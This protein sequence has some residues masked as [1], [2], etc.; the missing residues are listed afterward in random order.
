MSSNHAKFSPSSSHR[1]LACPGSISLSEQ[2]P[3]PPE[4]AA[5]LEGTQAHECLELILKNGPEKKLAT[6]RLLR[7]KYPLQMVVH[8]ALSA[9]SIWQL[10]RKYL[11]SALLLAE[12]RSELFHIDRDMHGTS[13]AVII[14]DFG[15]LQV[16]DYKYGRM[17]VEVEENPQ[18]IAYAIGIAHQHEYNFSEIICTVIQPRANHPDGPIRSWS[19]TAENLFEWSD[20]F[21]KGIRLAKHQDP[22]FASG[23]HCIFCPAKGICKSYDPSKVSSTK[24]RFITRATESDRKKQLHLDFKDPVSTN[25]SIKKSGAGF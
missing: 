3:D 20:R 15:T 13:D 10:K 21:R 14:E 23:E 19:T 24:S 9:V 17:P 18:L 16:I 25:K 4:S 6:E 2:C 12:T 22:P 11:S 1:W 5:A 8:A 7:E